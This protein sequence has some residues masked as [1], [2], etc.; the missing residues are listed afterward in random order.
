MLNVTSHTTLINMG[1]NCRLED[2]TLKLTSSTDV[3]NLTGIE[4]NGSSSQTSKLR[5]C[6]LTVD[7]SLVSSTSTTTVYGVDATGVVST[8]T[9]RSFAFNALKGSTINILSNGSGIKRGIIITGSNVITTRD[10]N[11]YV[12]APP[13]TAPFPGSY[14]GVETVDNAELGSIQLRST[15]VGAI[16]ST[17]A[18]SYTSSDILQTTPTTIT[19]P[20]YLASPGIQIG[21]GTDLITK[22]AGSKGFSTY[23]YPTTL[24]YGGIGD[25]GS[26]KTG[27]MWPGSVLF[28]GSYPDNTTPVARYRVQ[29]PLI[30][31][32]LQSTCNSITGVDSI[33]ITVCKNATTGSAL[34]NPTSFTVTLNSGT[35]SSSFYNASVDFA[36][37]DYINLYINVSGNSL[38]DL[39]IQLDLF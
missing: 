37:G 31:S 4:F 14:V 16:K 8:I 11:I 35:L 12:A 36:A 32:G 3:I 22:S 2:L 24:Y 19:N 21:P 34:S 18:Q 17:G 27:Y 23:T 1:E 9:P 10:L 6:V 39:S 5:T 7:N 33:V 13:T 15:T 29:Q 30:L 28:S 26:H 20:T 25:I 38:K